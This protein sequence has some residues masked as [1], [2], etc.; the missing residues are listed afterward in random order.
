[1]HHA[2]EFDVV[3]CADNS[4]PHLLSNEEISAALGQF[5]LCTRPGGLSIISIRD[6]ATLER[7]GLQIKPYGVRYD[8]SVRY[9]L[10]QVWEWRDPRM[11][12]EFS[13]RLL[14]YIVL[15]LVMTSSP[16][17]WLPHSTEARRMRFGLCVVVMTSTEVREPGT[18][19][20]LSTKP[21]R[22]SSTPKSETERPATPRFGPTRTF[23]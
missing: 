18:L 13:P 5:F 17:Y 22:M 11:R 4:L 6:Y 7:G 15:A 21:T 19:I 23:N 8:G 12:L 14:S 20:I 2:R 9:V 10:F 3:L 1:M 16:V